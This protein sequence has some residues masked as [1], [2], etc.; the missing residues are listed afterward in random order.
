MKRIYLISLM[1]LFAVSIQA[2]K[3]DL[4][5]AQ[6]VGLAYYFEHVSQFKSIQLKSI[7]ITSVFT[8][9]DNSVPVYYVFNINDNGFII[10]SADDNATPVL[11]YSYESNF[12]SDGLPGELKFWLGKVKTTIAEAINSNI[13]AT[14][15]IS[16]SWNYYKNINAGS[17]KTM[18]VK[19]VASL[20]TS[21]WDQGK[22]YNYYCPAATGGPDEKAWA[23]C[24]ATSMGQIM[25]YYRYP[26]QGQ[27]SHGGIN[28]GTTTYNWDNMLDNLT[29]YNDA[30][31]TLLYHAGKSVNMNYAA[32]GSG[33]QTYDVPSAV[34]NYFKYNSTCNYADYSFGGYNQ[35]SWINLI[36]SNLDL[37][38]PMIYSGFE[39][40]G[41]GHAWVCDGYDASNNLHMNWG[42]SGV[43]NGYFATTNL[44][45]GGYT[46]STG[47]GLV[48]NFF[49]PTTS[50]PTYCA[51]TK[52]DN[53]TTGTIEDG[54]GPY[55]Y[56]NNQDCLWLISPTE[57]ISKIALNFIT[58]STEPSNDIITVYDGNSTSAT[59]IGTYSGSTLPSTI[60]STGPEML[61]R[62]QTNGSTTSSG[63]KATYRSIYPVYCSGITTLITPTGTIDDGSG[64]GP[65]TYNAL[66]RWSIS[67]NLATSIT[68][69]FSAFDLAVGDSLRIYNQSTNAKLAGY[70]G[71]S[72][73]ATETYNITNLLL[74]FKTDGATNNQGFEASY[75]STSSAGI[76]EI[77]GLKEFSVFPNPANTK[78]NVQFSTEISET[79]KIKL[80]TISGQTVYEKSLTNFLGACNEVIETG[81]FP[82]G[83]YLLSINGENQAIHKKIIIE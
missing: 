6:N 66:C 38:H 63:W 33:A 81:S 41:G 55:D 28:F 25:Y 37:S 65:Y 54:S 39:S 60:T 73:P 18:K 47:F 72:I 61:V 3:V 80:S 32:D 71:S 8:E 52:T 1:L 10:V 45:A 58:L 69:S 23:G 44:T 16:S 53:F 48:Y 19:V 15:D 83:V 57:N 26:A 56:Q 67:P 12:K 13:S 30:V 35:T 42:W 40:S 22:Y 2:K 36:K 4:Q 68:L 77:N 11:G 5:T 21:T 34:K 59:V 14:P 31:A 27:G 70:S 51:G 76:G 50:Y 79:L 78:L 7:N 17:T 62:F 82:G 74:M 24:V 46:F 43:A 49:P 75:T 9:Y 29:N 20:L 64:T